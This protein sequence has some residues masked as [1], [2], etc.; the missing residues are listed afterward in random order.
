MMEN[1]MGETCCT[2]GKKINAYTFSVGKYE[3][4][5]DVLERGEGGRIILK[6]YGKNRMGRC[7]VN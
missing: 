1:W 3:G 7:G 5:A 6:L 2:H 4:T